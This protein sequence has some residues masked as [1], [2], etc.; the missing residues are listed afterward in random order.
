MKITRASM[1]CQSITTMGKCRLTK[2]DL[3]STACTLTSHTKNDSKHTQA[4]T[5]ATQQ[6]LN[7]YRT[8]IWH[9]GR[10]DEKHLQHVFDVWHKL[11]Y[12]LAYRNSLLRCICQVA[13][14]LQNVPSLPCSGHALSIAFT[15]LFTKLSLLNTCHLAHVH[16][17]TRASTQHATWDTTTV[18]SCHLAISPMIPHRYGDAICVVCLDDVPIF[19]KVSC[20]TSVCFRCLQS[21]SACLRT[22]LYRLKNVSFHRWNL[23]FG[24]G[25]EI[26]TVVGPYVLRAPETVPKNRGIPLAWPFIYQILPF[27][28][29]LLQ[30]LNVLPVMSLFTQL[31]MSGHVSV[32]LCVLAQPTTLTHEQK[33]YTKSLCLP[34]VWSGCICLKALCGLWGL[35]PKGKWRTLANSSQAPSSLFLDEDFQLHCGTRCTLSIH[36]LVFMISLAFTCSYWLQKSW[37]CLIGCLSVRPDTQLS[38][39]HKNKNVEPL[40]GNCSNCVPVHSYWVP[41][42]SV[43]VIGA[44]EFPLS[45]GTHGIWMRTK[46]SQH[47]WGLSWTACREQT[48]NGKDKYVSS[49]VKK[50][51]SHTYESYMV[52]NKWEILHNDE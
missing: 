35:W 22:T 52:Q 27:A 1:T 48:P 34:N 4:V 12:T 14:G 20:W 18:S 29:G 49:T 6:I 19:F 31:F 39:N 21:S 51:L 41:F 46:Q 36:V 28:R 40:Q 2:S 17:G 37:F 25:T 11:C 16:E 7:S 50:L 10:L 45:A 5:T 9:P 26:L 33:S 42:P 23:L 30:C 43:P 32:A 47:P 24:T 8:S 15:S 3:L 13:Y 38:R 44:K